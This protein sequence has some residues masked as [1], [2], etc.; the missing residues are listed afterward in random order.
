VAQDNY[1]TYGYDSRADSRYDSQANQFDPTVMDDMFPTPTQDYYD[2]PQHGGRPG[3]PTGPTPF[4]DMPTIQSPAIPAQRPQPGT[5]RPW[6]GQR[7]V[8]AIPSSRER[9][10]RISLILG[11]ISL[12]LGLIPVCGIVA[13]LPAAIGILYGWLGLQSR[14]RNMAILG[15]LLSLLAIAAAVSIVA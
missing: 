13:L 4:G 7:P 2:Q 8:R 3:G 6:R 11:V 9:M 5:R 12:A 14:Q 15:L 1:D 10:A